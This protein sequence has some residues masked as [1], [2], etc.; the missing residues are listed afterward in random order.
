MAYTYLIGW[1]KHN[2]F[3]YGVRFSKKSDPSELWVSYFTS[4]KYVKDFTKKHGTPDIIEIRKIFDN[5]KK[6]IEW[7]TKVLTRMNVLQSEKWINKTNNKAIDPFCALHGWSEKSRKKSSMSHTGKQRSQSHR[8][9]LS[10]AL[11]GRKCSW[12]N[13][14]SRPDHSEKMKGKNNPRALVVFY[15]NKKYETLKDLSETE[16]IS[17]YLIKK[18][19]NNQEIIQLKKEI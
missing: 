19:I 13:G 16:N 15:N 11:K 1:K 5:P 12:L 7:E 18:M 17:Y 8:D 14:K 9:N 6:A 10:L 4:S 2:K 3:Y